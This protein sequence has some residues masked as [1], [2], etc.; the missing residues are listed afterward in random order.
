MARW[1]LKL[2]A[3]NYHIEHCAGTNH[4]NANGLSRLP[5]IAHIMNKAE[6]LYKLL[7]TPE[8]WSKEVVG[9]QEI[10]T[11]M[12]ANTKIVKNQLFKLV[13][14][15]WLLYPPPSEQLGIIKNF[16]KVTGHAGNRKTLEKVCN[17]YYWESINFD[18][19]EYVNNCALCQSNRRFT[20]KTSFELVKPN[21]AWHT[22][23]ID[24]IG[25]LPKSNHQHL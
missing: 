8:L 24:L 17:D 11:R 12:K 6:R 9:I 4:Q 13:N 18:I 7:F 19:A 21:F 14:N 25:P 3:Y 2:Q 23:S 15:K 22:I 16:H 1:A 5:T 10:L 20:P